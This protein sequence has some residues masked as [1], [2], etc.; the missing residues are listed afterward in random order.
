PDS[1][2]NW[3]P[4]TDQMPSLAIG[5]I[6]FDPT[7]PSRVYAGSGEGNFYANLGA[8]VYHSTDGGATWAVLA[9][10][11][12]V[13]VGFYDLVVDRQNPTI[14]YAATSNGFYKSTNSGASWSLKRAGRCWDISVH[15]NGGSIEVLAT[16]GD[17]LFMSSNAG[18]SF[19]AVTLPAGPPSA[20]PRLAVDRVTTAPDIA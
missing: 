9:S 7:A 18:N 8:G 4:C 16:F 2:A 17:G 13:G 1:G 6:A 10:A 15:P 14:L 12:F 11:P 20:W 3:K 19:T 5:A